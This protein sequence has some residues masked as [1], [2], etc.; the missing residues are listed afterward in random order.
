M[1]TTD[2]PKGDAAFRELFVAHVRG[3]EAY[4]A[5]HYPGTDADD[6]V[7]E[8][9]AIAWRRWDD[10][11]VGNERAWLIGVARHLIHNT[12]RSARRRGAFVEA[13]IATRP[14]IST[15]LTGER[16]LVEHV[17]PVQRAFTRLSERDQEVLL[18]AAW[19]G[20]RGP[21]LG[22]ALGLT[23][24]QAADRLH[25]ARQRLRVHTGEEVESP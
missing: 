1:S 22:A 25:R 23:S 18:L 2:D 14:R 9:F 17:E 4:V 21:E 7:N 8:S 3:L 10:I 5:R 20:L 13:L 24:Q 16:L 12:V 15:E 11:P 6:I 19:E